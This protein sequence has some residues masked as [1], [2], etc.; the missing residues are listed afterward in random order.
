MPPEP[1]EFEPDIQANRVIQ[2][3]RER[4][5]AVLQPSDADLEHGL[6]LHRAS[7]V[8][9]CFGFLPGVWTPGLIAEMNQLREG[10][11]GARDWHWRTGLLR[12][13]AATRDRDGAREFVAAMKAS[14]LSGL[15]QTVAEGK[16]REQDIKRMALSRHDCHVFR[17]H[18]FQGAFADEVAEA[19]EQGRCCIFWSV[20]GPPCPGAM[21]DPDEELS[22]VEPW[23][24]LGVRLMHLTYNRRN[25]VGDGCLEDAN[26]GLSD[27]GRELVREMNRVGIVV[28]IPHSGGRTTLDAARVSDKPIMAS[29][30][31]CRALHDHPRSKTDEE[32]KAIADNG[33]MIGVYT[34]PGFLGE[35]A[36][37]ATMLD[38]IDYAVKLL[39]PHHVGIGTDMCYAPPWPEEVP[40]IPNARWSSSWWGAWTPETSGGASDEARSGSLAWTNWPLFTVGLV[41]R[42]HSDEDVRKIIGGNLLRVLRDNEPGDLVKDI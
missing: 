21:I 11:I 33:G 32:L 18:L 26:S 39:G 41:M 17:R 9:D 5:L 27:F 2:Q 10:Q 36:D 7:L 19:K 37:L 34:I 20:N 16:T 30:T 3:A 35:N 14:G 15:V 12:G 23:Y 38:H 8:C 40:G 13:V 29:H 4:A 6:E 25:V 22:W 31:G 28:D 24:H 42:G 1:S